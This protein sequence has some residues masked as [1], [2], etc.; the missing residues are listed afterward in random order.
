MSTHCLI[1]LLLTLGKSYSQCES[2]INSI[3]CPLLKCFQNL[4]DCLKGITI[5]GK[6]CVENSPSTTTL[7][8]KNFT[9]ESQILQVCICVY[10]LFVI[11]CRR[12]L[13]TYE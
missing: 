9:S 1:I 7:P 4:E 6:T 11:D 2:E 5:N 3:S 12:K 8:A 13:V 10:R